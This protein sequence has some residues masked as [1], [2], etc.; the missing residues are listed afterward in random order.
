MNLK[1]RIHHVGFNETFVEY[2]NASMLVVSPSNK[3]VGLKVWRGSQFQ[4]TWCDGFQICE[5][6]PKGAKVNVVKF[7]I[8]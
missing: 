2:K 5:D 4:M 8:K 7:P 1:L 6:F 3:Q